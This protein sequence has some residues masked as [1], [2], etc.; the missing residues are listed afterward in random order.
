MLPLLVFAP[1]S[2]GVPDSLCYF[3]FVC[4]SRAFST[5]AVELLLLW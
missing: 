5:V 3:I 4:Q 2:S 1:T